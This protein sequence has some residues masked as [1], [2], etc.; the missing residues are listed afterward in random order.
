LRV[1]RSL[2]LRN[3]LLARRWPLIAV[4]VASL[5]LVS[6]AVGAAASGHF[7]ELLPWLLGRSWRVDLIVVFAFVLAVVVA[8]AWPRF[9]IWCFESFFAV[10]GFLGSN[11]YFALGLNRLFLRRGRVERLLNL[12]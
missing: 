9:R 3:V 4:V 2:F 6:V 12:K 1:G 7:D 8:A 10:F 11:L 5:I